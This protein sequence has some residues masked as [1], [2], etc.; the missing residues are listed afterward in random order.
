[1]NFDLIYDT[2][3]KMCE[4]IRAIFDLEDLGVVRIMKPLISILVAFVMAFSGMTIVFAEETNDLSQTGAAVQNEQTNDGDQDAT[5]N[6]TD[7]SVQ[8]A[9]GDE[10]VFVTTQPAM[11]LTGEQED[12]EPEI[13]NGVFKSSSGSYKLYIYDDGTLAYADIVKYLGKDKFPKNFTISEIDGYKIRQIRSKAFTN[14]KTLKNV[15]F[16]GTSFS[17]KLKSSVEKNAFCNCKNMAS[18]T[19]NSF[20]TLNTKCV[21]YVNGKRSKSFKTLTFNDVTGTVK[22]VSSKLFFADT[23]GIN[24]VYNVSKDNKHN[25]TAKMT[26]F[27]NGAE[28]QAKVADKTVKGWK[29]SNPKA[30][31]ISKD[32]KAVVLS[33]GSTTLSVKQGKLIIKRVFRVTTNP[34]LTIKGEKVS[35]VTVKNGKSVQLTAQG[36]AEDVDNVYTNTG[37]AEF[38]SGEDAEVLR[39]KATRKGSTTLKV[40]VN[41]VNLRV[42]VTVEKNPITDERMSLIADRIGHQS[43]Y[44]YADSRV[45]CSAYA[46]C[47]AYYQVKGRRISPG[48]QWCP[49]GCMWLGGTYTHYGSRA[50]MLKAIKTSLDKNQACVGLLSIGNSSTHYVTFY[51][52]E[53]DGKDLGDFK[54]LDPWDGNLTTGEYYGYSYGYHVVTIDT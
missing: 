5:E 32:G 46:F 14:L 39:I 4:K 26:D 35:S 36:K 21:G 48:S 54:I 24:A 20:V 19:T 28:F 17:S 34:Y 49:G 8:D 37:Y 2:I 44:Y 50:R 6:T 31:S 29:S 11:L 53:D 7:T 15:K 25:R 9:T 23:N 45:M 3:K 52:Y 40:N 12:A 27:V 43:Q 33:R 42:K 1:M 16:M 10:Q 47:Y 51:D 38:T 18:F 13:K 22:D 41:G 30:I